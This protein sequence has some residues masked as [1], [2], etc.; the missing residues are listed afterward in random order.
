MFRWRAMSCLLLWASIWPGLAE[1]SPDSANFTKAVRATKVA[2]AL[3]MRWA[4]RRWSWF[5]S[6]AEHKGQDRG[7]AT[8][9]WRGPQPL[10]NR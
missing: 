10:L 8:D 1:A 4:W 2:R 7:Q 9:R 3:P 5:R 6:G